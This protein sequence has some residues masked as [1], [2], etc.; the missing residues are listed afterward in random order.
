MI[1]MHRKVRN[2]ASNSSESPIFYIEIF[3]DKITADIIITCKI[4]MCASSVVNMSNI[5]HYLKLKCQNNTCP[6]K[7]MLQYLNKVQ[8]VN[9]MVL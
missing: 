5:R 7:F 6:V 8:I 3:A 2:C 9:L 4:L 1:S